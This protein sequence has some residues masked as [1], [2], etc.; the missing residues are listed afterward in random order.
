ML[1]KYHPTVFG[2]IGL[3]AILLFCFICK[4]VEAAN[5][6]TTLAALPESITELW[7]GD[8]GWLLAQT[9]NKLFEVSVT[10]EVKENVI[11]LD[12]KQSSLPISDIGW[13]PTRLA[14][15][16]R[17]TKRRAYSLRI[18][19]P[20]PERTISIPAV[21]S[22]DL[23]HE[24]GLIL[25]HTMDS[26]GLLPGPLQ[27]FDLQGQPIPQ[28]KVNTRGRYRADTAIADKEW[29]VAVALANEKSPT[30]WLLTSQ[31]NIRWKQVLDPG[32][33]VEQVCISGSAN[34]VILSIQN[35]ATKKSQLILLSLDDGT[36]K[37]KIEIPD[38]SG[39]NLRLSPNGRW[40]TF[41]G[42]CLIGLVDVAKP[43][44]LWHTLYRK[45]FDYWFQYT[46]VNDQGVIVAAFADHAL[47][48]PIMLL[49]FD[50]AGMAS[51]LWESPE[52]VDYA[53]LPKGRSV[54]WR[55]DGRAIILR[56]GNKVLAFNAVKATANRI[57]GK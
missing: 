57:N 19:R 23:C 56:Y 42:E 4:R 14:I 45:D 29:V 52:K 33:M 36:P 13:Q 7:T 55:D 53:S 54:F 24:A 37:A 25:C 3:I 41:S 50:N 21:Y 49:L 27:I 40:L 26:E 34:C 39:Q 6:V 32:W 18:I 10:G 1:A 11:S 46:D 28:W 15:I 16:S 38:W 17:E 44:V 43:G 9:K 2:S 35:R 22:V 31:G 8:N 5:D 12:E 20:G 30:C 47:P 51:Q 48:G